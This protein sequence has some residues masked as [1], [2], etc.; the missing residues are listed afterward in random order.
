MISGCVPAG[1]ARMA[2]EYTRALEPAPSRHSRYN[3]PMVRPCLLRSLVMMS[4]LTAMGLGPP[5]GAASPESAPQDPEAAQ[6]QIE[7]V[8][9]RIEAV[10]QRLAG[11]RQRRDHVSNRL[12]QVEQRIGELAGRIDE[13]D[14]RL[15]QSRA[16]LNELERRRESLSQELADHRQ[17]LA[18]QLRAAYRMGRRP[19]LRLLLG[20]DDPAAA[21]RALGY[22]AYINEARVGA[23]ERADQLLAEIGRVTRATRQTQQRLRSDRDT[24]AAQRAELGRKRSE[25][26]QLLARLDRSIASDDARLG[27]LRERRQRLEDV[28]AELEAVLGDTPPAPLEDEPFAS[29]SGELPWPAEGALRTPFG[30]DRAGGRMQWSGMV[31]AA[32]AGATVRAVYHGRVVFADWLSGF[33]QLIILDHQDGHLTLYGF[34]Q[35][36]LRG[37][38]D[39][40][41]PGEPIA[42][43][44]SSGGRDRPGLY[45]EIR[46]RGEPVDP[47]PWLA[48]R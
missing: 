27:Q 18:A 10:Q 25:R 11:E 46:R 23:M 19:G 45:F 41:A 16:R 7:A 39:W 6:A 22:Y 3:R 1:P 14:A 48:A 20:Q 43:V 34:N 24:L 13:L 2:G 36:L 15:N 33:G 35:R 21:T 17:T 9:E 31:I 4:A 47:L 40:V 32:E 38:G 12:A 5:A 42:K 37:H 44:G 30:A 8:R 28:L 26:R 29:R